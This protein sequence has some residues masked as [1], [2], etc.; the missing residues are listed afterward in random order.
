MSKCSDHWGKIKTIIRYLASTTY[1]SSTF[2]TFCCK[3][4]IIEKIKWHFA[5]VCDKHHT[6]V[7]IYEK[8]QIFCVQVAKSVLV[9]KRSNFTHAEQFLP[10]LQ[11]PVF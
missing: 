4:K 9:V 2:E 7:K 8:Q 11:I 5:S 1:I 10:T 6:G 3:I